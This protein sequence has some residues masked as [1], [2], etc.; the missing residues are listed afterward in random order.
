MGTYAALS[1]A[2]PL[3]V[4][5]ATCWVKGSASDVVSQKMLEKKAS[6]DWRRNFTLATYSGLYCGCAQ[7]G[8]VNVGFQR[9]FGMATDL[10]TVFWMVAADALLV[11]PL[12]NMPVYYSFKESLTGGVPLEGIK[13]YSEQWLE[14]MKPYWSLWTAFNVFLFRYTPLELRIS[15]IACMSFFWLTILSYTTNKE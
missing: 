15:L 9:L 6:I 10:K 7:H 1:S 3:S 4:A 11:T 2:W 12:V 14:V 5:F 13:R 8:I